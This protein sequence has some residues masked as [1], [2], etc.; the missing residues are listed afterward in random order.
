MGEYFIAGRD[1]Q[2]EETR[3][4]ETTNH[5]RGSTTRDKTGRDG[6]KTRSTGKDLQPEESRLEALRLEETAKK[7][8]T[9][10]DYQSI[11]PSIL[12]PCSIFF[13]ETKIAPITKQNHTL[14]K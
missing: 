1:G 13:C 2:P 3:P 8:K 10:R 6:Q 5:K 4:E 12:C 9:G 7:D 14:I 11:H